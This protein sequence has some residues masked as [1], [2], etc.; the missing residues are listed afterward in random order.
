MGG[1]TEKVDHFT[2]KRSKT[3]GYMT[4]MNKMAL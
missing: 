4:K 1:M 3:M 2:N